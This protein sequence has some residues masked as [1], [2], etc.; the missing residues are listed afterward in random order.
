MAVR[1]IFAAANSKHGA[2]ETQAVGKLVLA[3]S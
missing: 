2:G 1:K 3:V